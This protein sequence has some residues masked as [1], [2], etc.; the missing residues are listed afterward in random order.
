MALW[1]G[2]IAALYGPL[3]FFDGELLIP[4][5][6]VALLAWALFFVLA[7]RS[8]WSLVTASALLGLAVIARPNAL[9]LIPVFV[10]F[11]WRG[12]RENP[13]IRARLIAWLVLV[14]FVPAILVTLLNAKS[15]G[16]FVFVASQGGVN[17]YAGNNPHA[18][19][20]TL[21]VRE[22]SGARGS[23]AD[24]VSASQRVA[25]VDTGG[26]LS[27]RGV[28]GYWAEKA[29]KWA[30]DDPAAAL[31]ITLKKAYFLLN[32]YELPNNRDLYFERPFP[33]KVLMWQLGWF[34]FPWGFILPLGAAGAILGFRS[35]KARRV[36][37]LL[38]GWIIVYAAFLI[39]FFVC[40]R[41]RMGLVPPLVLLA[42]FALSRGRELLRPG[43]LVAVGVALIV[44]N[45]NFFGTR[46]DDPMQELARR[47]VTYIAAGRVDEGRLALR[48]VIDSKKNLPN[49]PSYIGEFAYQ[50]GE[51]YARE[52]DATRA[53]EYF[54]ESLALGC[55][56]YRMLVGMAGYASEMSDDSTAVAALERAAVVHTGDEYL[57]VDL[58][59]A[60]R[61]TGDTERAV[62]AFTRAID[63][64]PDNAR[65]YHALG[66]L[67]QGNAQ[68]DSA[69]AVWELGSR[70]APDSFE[71][72]YNIALLNAQQGRTQK[73][74]ATLTA[75]LALKPDDPD[76]LSLREMLLSEEQ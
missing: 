33:L 3:I 67:Y 12:A 44:S 34:S 72:H 7:K 68:P 62:E 48:T 71:L 65:A 40:A 9:I 51:T 55:T 1:A 56:T 17:L 43:P 74:L 76:A 70:H 19:G 15:E 28:S 22:L 36:S 10:L 75:A 16:A 53:K 23:W 49:P 59:T 2:A 38:G 20:R 61:K 46:M 47:G 13:L 73:A 4:N 42:A 21:A 37:V 50:L 54:R 24:F 29:W 58:G 52:G 64:A 5:L 60:Y 18:T 25:E 32:S 63:I 66:L 45:T 6:L 35:R 8:V 30:V 11:V 26:P 69:L 39:P 14:A 31:G 27:S 41:F 57:L